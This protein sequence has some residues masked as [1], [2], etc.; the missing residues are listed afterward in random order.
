MRAV[1]WQYWFSTAEQKRQQGVWWIRQYLGTYAPTLT[2][3]PDGQFGVL[4]G[5]SLEGPPQP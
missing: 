3:L 4:A 1:L 5:P 2:R